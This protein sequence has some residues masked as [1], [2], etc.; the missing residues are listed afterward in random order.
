LVGADFLHLMSVPTH[1][2][3][4]SALITHLK[5]GD[6]TIIACN[7]HGC[8]APVDKR[9]CEERIIASQEIINF[10]SQ[11]DGHKIIAVDFN[12]YPDTRSIQLFSE[13]GYQNLIRDYKIS[14]TRGTLAKQMHPEY[15]IP[16]S[17]FQEFAD[18]M[19]VSP[20]IMVGAFEVPDLPLSD[21]L[22]MIVEFN[23]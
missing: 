4:G 13:A 21:H 6:Q 10:M 17:V 8:A 7:V 22:P 9:D 18:Y 1:F 15:G 2:S 11:F 20:R 16:P 3:K 19:F 14:T 23:F 12:L 5:F